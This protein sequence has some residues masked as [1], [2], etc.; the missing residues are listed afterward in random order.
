[1]F[2]LASNYKNEGMAA[3]SRFQEKEFEFEKGS[4]YMATTHQKFVG[5]GYFDRI[6]EAI[7]GGASSVTALDG[8]TEQAQFDQGNVTH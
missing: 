7:S 8:S 2:N 1:M 5:T 4:G 6:M 3:Y